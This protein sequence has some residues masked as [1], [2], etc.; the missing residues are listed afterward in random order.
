M[1]RLDADLCICIGVK[2]D[3]NYENPFYTHSKYRFLYNE[4]EDY[5]QA[6]DEAYHEIM[7]EVRQPTTLGRMREDEVPETKHWR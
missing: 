4:P 7:S 1:D 2:P 5:G 6:F 3:Y